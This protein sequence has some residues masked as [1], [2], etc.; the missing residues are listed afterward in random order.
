[1][2]TLQ[3]H[4]ILPLV[5]SPK[6][7]KIKVKCFSFL[8]VYPIVYCLFSIINKIRLNFLLFTTITHC[9]RDL[10]YTSVHFV[11][12]DLIALSEF[13]RHEIP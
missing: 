11:I 1:M 12:F 3:S 8:N 7:T 6:L 9:Y 10:E 2:T 13:H 4:S 5:E